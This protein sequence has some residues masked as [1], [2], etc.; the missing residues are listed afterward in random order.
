MHR[1]H[2]STPHRQVTGRICEH[3]HG[4]GSAVIGLG[5]VFCPACHGTGQNTRH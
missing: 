5:E 3:C 1:G 4:Y 2:A